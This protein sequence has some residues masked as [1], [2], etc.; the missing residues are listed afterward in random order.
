MGEEKRRFIRWTKKVRV[1]CSF[2]ED[3]EAFEEVFAENISETGLQLVLTQPLKQNQYLKLRLEFIYDSVPIVVTGR[4]V[5]M[6]PEEKQ[7]RI[8]LEFVDVDDFQ[9]RRLRLCLEKF[10]QNPEG[11]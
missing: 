7:Y 6:S 4:V 9:R 8:G 3:E 5:H 10:S 1:V 2:R 11:R